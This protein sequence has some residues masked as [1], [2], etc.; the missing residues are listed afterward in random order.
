MINKMSILSTDN[1]TVEALKYH[2]FKSK[3]I[4]ME[5]SLEDL[6]ISDADVLII[7]EQ[8]PFSLSTTDIIKMI[9]TRNSKI[10]IIALVTTPIS[11]AKVN[12]LNAGSDDC[13]TKPINPL[14]I[15]ARVNA[16]LRREQSLTDKV[17]AYE[18]DKFYDLELDNN[19]RQFFIKGQEVS[20]TKIEFLTLLY[21][22]RQKGK[23]VSR[24]VLLKDIWQRDADDFSRLVDNVIRRLR[25]KL[26]ENQSETEIV[27]IW[28]QGY[29]IE[30]Q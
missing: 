30:T 9:R 19:R 26:A 29:R 12:N 10:I 16:I 25:K 8:N 18:E 6:V 22:V 17:T 15:S 1:K 5:T 11:S 28:G 2:N 7:D 4:V 27:S 21:L 24:D 3:S 20:L 14:E 23:I 13:V